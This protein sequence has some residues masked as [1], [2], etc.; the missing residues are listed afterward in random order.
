MGELAEERHYREKYGW[1]FKLAVR[2]NL[3]MPFKIARGIYRT[4]IAPEKYRPYSPDNW[5][6]DYFYTGELNDSATIDWDKPAYSTIYHYSTIEIMMLRHFFHHGVDVTGA[7]VLDIGSG[8][9]HWL[10][11]Y[12]K[13]KAGTVTGM[14][15]SEKSARYLSEKYAGDDSVTILHGHVAELPENSGYDVV[16]AIGVMFHIVDDD[17]WHRA[18]QKLWASVRPGGVMVIGGHFGMLSNLNVQFDPDGTVNK[19]LRSRGQWKRELEGRSKIRFYR[20]DVALRIADTLP[21][22]NLLIAHKA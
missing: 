3:K 18:V 21:E 16:N 15:I 11:F 12:R 6:D 22:S 14:D 5:W 19:R 13:L 2:L 9:G 20:N 7:D 10:E 4:Y 17:E 8:A 1:L